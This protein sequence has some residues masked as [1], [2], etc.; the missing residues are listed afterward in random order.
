MCP[1]PPP[2]PPRA[3]G[4]TVPFLPPPT[5][6]AAPTLLAGRVAAGLGRPRALRAC[7][8]ALQWAVG[9][10]WDVRASARDEPCGAR[11]VSLA[12]DSEHSERRPHTHLQ[13]P[14]ASAAPRRAPH[15]ALLPL[16]HPVVL[17]GR[18]RR[19]RGSGDAGPPAGPLQPGAHRCR[20]QPVMVWWWC[21]GGW[22]GGWVGGWAGG[23]VG[24][25]AGGWVGGVGLFT[26]CGMAAS[27]SQR[28]R[29]TDAPVV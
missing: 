15:P 10:V 21:S 29:F 9:R 17:A 4:S 3:A 13:F 6:T 8:C 16:H 5:S 14:P 22:A 2:P 28:R 25:W 1:P 23:W 26:E 20:R 7:P 18:R 12:A 11:V 24:G 27:L 19:A